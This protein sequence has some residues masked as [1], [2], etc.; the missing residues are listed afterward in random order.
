[1]TTT[2]A[3]LG[4]GGLAI[5]RAA[6]K[7]LENLIG[8]L[9]LLLDKA[10]QTGDFCKIGD[11]VGKVEDIGLRS[12]KLRLLD[13]NLLVVP[14]GVLAQMQFENMKERPKLLIN[15][16]FSLR[17][18]TEVEQLRFVLDRVQKMLDE[19]PA[20]EAGTSRVRV[21]NFAGAAFELELFAYGKTSEW[22][23]LT[24]IRQDVILKIAGIVEAAGTRF[25]APTRLTYQSKDP[26]VDAD[27]ASDIVRQ[28]AE[29]R[30]N[31][32]F[33]IPGEVQTVS[34]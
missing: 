34:K 27:K 26:G 28:V 31:H 2:L 13:Q 30:A 15:Q 4:I 17:I 18:E 20:I 24:A 14:N 21:T 7:T 32:A 8:G 16:T 11:R 5:A 22:P 10:V 3:G 29:L 19:E 23:E 6:Q 25:A 33:R 12:L 9:S 1:V